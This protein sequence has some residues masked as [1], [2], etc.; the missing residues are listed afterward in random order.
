MNPFDFAVGKLCWRD[1]LTILTIKD[2]SNKRKAE[3]ERGL[4]K[5]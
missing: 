5:L 3:S 2:K 4:T 1:K